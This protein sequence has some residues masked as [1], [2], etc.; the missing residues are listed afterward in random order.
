MKKIIFILFALVSITSQAQDKLW[1]LQECVEYALENNISV[2]QSE[3]DLQNAELNKKDAFGNFLPSLNARVSH[4]WNIGLN[5]DPVTFDAVNS[6]TRNLSGGISSGV[7]IYNG[8]RNLN[9]LRRSNLEI[10]A[11]Q[12]QLD[13][14]KDNMSLTIAN[15]FL[16]ILFNK[17]Q[18]KVLQAQQAITQEELQRTTD[19]VEAGSLPRG[20][21]LEI[22]ATI[23]SQ[24]Q[25]VVNAENAIFL[26]KISLAQLLLI[27][28][29]ENFDI[30]DTAYEVPPTSILN[31]S[32]QAII[33]K[34]KETRYDI[35]IAE[36]NSEIA[37]YN[38]KIAKGAI[39]PTLS[40][41]YS[42]G[43]NYFRSQLFNTPEFTDQVS[44]NKSHGFS[45][46]LNIPIFNGFSVRNNIK[47]SEIQIENTK[48]LLE[49]ANLD[50]ETNVYQAY[51]DA[52][53]ALKAYEAALKTEEARSEA[54]NYSKARYDVG[55]LNA[56]DFSQSKNR[57][58]NAQSEVV[59]TKYDYIFKLKVLEFYF[60]IPIT[61]LN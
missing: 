33:A 21:L 19:L 26:S 10:L 24:D 59:R 1:T 20:D 13:N 54:F 51:N 27:E 11:S 7:N 41:S 43:T 47:R 6:T 15:A 29:Y 18:L 57:L 8:L 4:S 44:D 42:F 55:L 36:N 30:I 37:E 45:L 17:E 61:A 38:L 46:N 34:A 25:Q 60:G 23:A 16:Q 52:K 31:E 58:E 50:L 53:G 22:E 2:K 14:M 5:Q 3:L 9:Q 39:Q 49:Q 12:Y 35:K 56:F 40:G 32:P 48:Y 28:D